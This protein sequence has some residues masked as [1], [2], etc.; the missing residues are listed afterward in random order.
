MKTKRILASLAAIAVAVTPVAASAAVQTSNTAI[1]ATI[2][3]VISMTTSGT[4][5]I[6]L[7][8]TV[9]GVVSSASDTVTVNTNRTTGYNLKLSASD[10]TANLT[11]GANTITPHAGTF[12]TPTALANGT[13]GYRIVNAGGFTA[14]AYSAETNNAAS[15][16]TWAGVPTNAAPQTVKTTATTATNDVTTVWYAAKVTSSQPGGAY[17]DTVTYT[18]TTN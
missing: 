2:A 9:G 5:A 11:S 18:A 13:W 1:N 14:T 4:V 8:P 17:S 6:S 15:T 7:T 12:G 10:A 16:S 3:D